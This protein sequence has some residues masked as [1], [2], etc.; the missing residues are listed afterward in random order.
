MSIITGGHPMKK[1]WV[2]DAP[3]ARRFT[4]ARQSFLR[5]ILPYFKQGLDLRTALDVGCGVGHFSTFLRDMGFQVT[6]VDGRAENV[7]EAQKRYPNIPFYIANV[8][9]SSIAHL[10][11]FDLVL[12]FGLLYHLENPFAAMR[13]LYA[14]TTKVLL[15]E[16]A[17]VPE[18]R[19]VLILRDEVQSEDQGLHFIAFYPSESAI[20]KMCYRSGFP[21]VYRFLKL[22]DHEDFHASVWRQRVRTMLVASHLPL[23]F[24]FLELVTEPMD[25][26]D[27]WE[28]RMGKVLRFL[29]RLHRFLRKPWPE[30]VRS[31]RYHF[32]RCVNKAVPFVPLPTRLPWG[33]YWLA[34]NDVCGDAVFAGNF[35]EAERQFV[36]R[37]LKPSMIVLDIGAHHGFYTLLASYKV[38]PIG[39]VIAFEPSP[40]EYQRLLWHL[41]LNRR[42]NVLAE[43]FALGSHEGTTQLF[44]VRGRDTGCNSLRP[45][46]TADPASPVQVPIVRLD[47]YLERQGI[48]HVDF[49]KMDV[50][51]AELE[52]LRGATSLLSRKPRPVWMMEVQDIRTEAFGYSAKDIVE[53]LRERD[54]HW[55]KITQQGKLLPLSDPSELRD[56]SGYNFVAVP[57]ER[58]EEVQSLMDEAIHPC[59]SSA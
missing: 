23:N 9:D 35:E 39:Q 14:L 4:E 55:F 13:N 46:K 21:F 6:G 34:Y 31:L 58:L 43:P 54:F 45:P 33:D 51:G 42:K 52:V 29:Q 12:C 27:P 40:R 19:S 59:P 20:V 11:K 2:F 15:I 8:E 36:E 17:T 22:P 7:T 37:F 56:W 1:T 30:K 25:W 48:T 41:R 18:Q 44:L 49:V 50:E 24:P 10:G 5:L 3:H 57:T 16:S 32:K 47:D 53:F 28:T 26:S 38:G